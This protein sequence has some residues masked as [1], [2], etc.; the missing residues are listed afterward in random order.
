[1]ETYKVKILTPGHFIVFR[2]KRFR[3]PVTISNV[4]KR[5]LEFVNAQIRMHSL[6][7]EI[8]A[9]VK[10]NPDV[11]IEELKEF[12]N[13]IDVSTEEFLNQSVDIDPPIE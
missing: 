12:S 3:S 2:G 5:E 4:Y 1:M 8:E 10:L 7:F 6:K 9:E 11:Y 13:D